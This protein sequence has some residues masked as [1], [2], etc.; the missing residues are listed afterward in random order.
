MGASRFFL[1]MEAAWEPR[2]GETIARRSAGQRARWDQGSVTK[3]APLE[4]SAEVQA[5]HMA[6]HTGRGHNVEGEAIAPWKKVHIRI[7]AVNSSS[8]PLLLNP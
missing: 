7:P 3:L 4:V 8:N 1:Q 6:T 2:L 5:V